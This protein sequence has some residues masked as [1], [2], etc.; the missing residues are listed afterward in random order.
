MNIFKRSAVV[1]LKRPTTFA[2]AFAKVTGVVIIASAT[3]YAWFSTHQPIPPKKITF[4]ECAQALVGKLRLTFPERYVVVVDVPKSKVSSEAITS[5]FWLEPVIASALTAKPANV[6]LL[7]PDLQR[8][9]GVLVDNATDGYIREGVKVKKTATLTISDRNA[10]NSLDSNN[11]PDIGLTIAAKNPFRFNNA[12][13][14]M[15][16]NVSYQA[17]YVPEKD[18][19]V[20]S[21]T[22][23]LDRKNLYVVSYGGVTREEQRIMNGLVECFK[24][25]SQE[26][27]TGKPYQDRFNPKLPYN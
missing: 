7:S 9:Q 3:W 2:D 10:Y 15:G 12:F 4:E 23:T 27:R 6:N 11:A 21:I 24:N 18:Y 8:T 26:V 1:P 19:L 20:K 22:N 5:R 13:G 14:A 25:R 16:F 17:I